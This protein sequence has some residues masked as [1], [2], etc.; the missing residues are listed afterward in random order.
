MIPLK[1]KKKGNSVRE[2]VP[3]GTSQSYSNGKAE[4]ASLLES[5]YFSNETKDFDQPQV[6]KKDPK[7]ALLI[8]DPQKRL[9]WFPVSSLPWIKKTLE[10]FPH[11][12]PKEL[13]L[14]KNKQRDHKQKYQT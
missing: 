6:D 5:K 12:R 11:F 9:S 1:K 4:G 8:R 13:T 7:T 3:M 14:S 10:S 2:I